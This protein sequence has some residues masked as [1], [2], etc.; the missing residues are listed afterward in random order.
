MTTSDA[1]AAASRDAGW[2]VAAEAAAKTK[3]AAT[4]ANEKDDRERLDTV[5]TVD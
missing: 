1:C 4:H 2:P 5:P 3:I